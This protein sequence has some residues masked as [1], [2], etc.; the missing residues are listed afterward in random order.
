MINAAAQDLRFAFRTLR[1]APLFTSVAVVSLALGIG[2]HTA[3]FSLIDQL[4]SQMLPVAEPEQLVPLSPL[5]PVWQQELASGELVSGNYFPVLAVGAALGRVFTAQDDLNQDRQHPIA[6]LSYGYW[7]RRFAGDPDVLGKKLVLNGYPV[8]VAGVSSGGFD[9]VEPTRR[10]V[11]AA[12]PYAGRDR[13]ASR[14]SGAP[15]R[16][17]DPGKN[18]CIGSRG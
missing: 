17:C 16:V 4:I 2:A 12:Y 1:K 13:A 11:G 15:G 3:I 7:Q 5:G 9:G 6:V 18:R 14:R 10:L 8:T